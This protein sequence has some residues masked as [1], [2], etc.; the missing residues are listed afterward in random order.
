MATLE[1][2]RNAALGF[3]GIWMPGHSLLRSGKSN[4]YT[5]LHNAFGKGRV[6]QN[7]LAALGKHLDRHAT[8]N[9]KELA[10]HVAKA[11]KTFN[12]TKNVM[13]AYRT[14]RETI[15]QRELPIA[16]PWKSR[17]LWSAALAGVIAG[18]A[19]GERIARHVVSGDNKPKPTPALVIKV[20]P[21]PQAPVKIQTLRVQPPK[22]A[23]ETKTALQTEIEDSISEL[24]KD[25]S[26]E[27]RDKVSIMVH[28]IDSG[29]TLA[30][31]NSGK[32]V[33]ASLIKPFVMLAA[34]HR[35]KEAHWKKPPS[36]LR[37]AVHRMI[38]H[39]ENP[40]TDD[41]IRYA[42]G[43]GEV[44]RIAKAYGFTDTEVGAFIQ[45]DIETHKNKTSMRD[46]NEFLRRLHTEDL[47]SP[48]FA[49]L[50]RQHLARYTTSRIARMEEVR[51]E[52]ETGELQ[53][54]GKTGNVYGLNGEATHVTFD[55][56]KRRY[57][58]V[59]AIQNPALHNASPKKGEPW[60][61]EKS[62][63]I[64]QLFRRVHHHMTTR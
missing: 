18:T 60:V 54:A 16:K 19:I 43:L 13:F 35:A 12:Q 38:A 5:A 46:L 33:A 10:G 44:E 62:E 41:L 31:I 7:E 3:E 27:Q 29:K 8:S 63:V 22:K 28:D 36:W 48:A 64:R 49:Q 59:I 40:A 6:S 1:N 50:M 45:K 9:E 14:L 56:G 53:L 25:G 42:G 52:I 11:E 55:H 57:N 30:S 17:L 32:I 51:R 58:L 26:L 4:F 21:R 39:S 20:K 2:V 61:K 34:Y 15:R 24:Q 47:V 37:N 23:V